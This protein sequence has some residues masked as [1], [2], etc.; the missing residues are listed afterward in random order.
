MV[1]GVLRTAAPSGRRKRTESVR[2]VMPTY[3]LTYIRAIRLFL[4]SLN[5]EVNRRLPSAWLK[6][7]TLRTIPNTVA[8]ELGGTKRVARLVSIIIAS[9]CSMARLLW[10]IPI[11]KMRNWY[12]VSILRDCLLELVADMS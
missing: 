3:A 6:E 8:T 11:D 2:M 9:V 10:R 7:L 12:V 1:S 4:N 5:T